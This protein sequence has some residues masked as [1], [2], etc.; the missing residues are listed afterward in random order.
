MR[1][2]WEHGLVVRATRYP[3]FFDYNALVVQ[4]PTGLDAAALAALADVHLAGLGHRRLEFEVEAEAARL[5]PGFRALGWRTFRLV[6]MR[7]AG[8]AP[9]A[10]ETP[11][12]EVDFDAVAE[13]RRTWLEE[14]FPGQAAAFIADA[15]E[16]SL[17]RGARVLAALRD[18]APIGFAQVEVA[19]DGAEVDAVYVLP[20]H[21]GR[22]VGGAMTAAAVRWALAQAPRDIWIVADA[23]GRPRHLYER[24][25]F[26]PV[27]IWSEFLLAH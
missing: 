2:P 25:G 23:D 7:F 18:G 1:E 5:V 12:S 17:A 10:G 15:R 21:R 27:R 4:R 6:S 22:G 20:A 8:P 19:G 14:D 3:N 16:V 11:V 26:V 13:L 24:L 9:A